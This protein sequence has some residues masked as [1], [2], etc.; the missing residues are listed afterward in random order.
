MKN[1]RVYTDY[2]LLPNNT[3]IDTIHVSRL[4]RARALLN[5]NENAGDRVRPPLTVLQ[6]RKSATSE[7][8]KSPAL[9]SLLEKRKR[10]GFSF[11]PGE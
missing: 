9:I 7:A 10:R 11:Q 8:Q 1:Q 6:T 2:E 4:P 5:P 3:I